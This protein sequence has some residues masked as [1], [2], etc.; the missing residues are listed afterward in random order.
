MKTVPVGKWTGR[1]RPLPLLRDQHD[2]AEY[3]DPKGVLINIVEQDCVLAE[4]R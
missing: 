2:P 3:K 1:N 4:K